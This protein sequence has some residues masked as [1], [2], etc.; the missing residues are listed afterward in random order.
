MQVGKMPNLFYLF[1]YGYE[2]LSM[3]IY[4]KTNTKTQLPGHDQGM[5]NT[6]C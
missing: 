2:N 6:N 1:K 3:V 4:V 5:Q